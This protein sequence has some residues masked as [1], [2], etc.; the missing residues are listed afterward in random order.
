[1]ST[2]SVA[3]AFTRLLALITTNTTYLR[4]NSF[5]AQTHGR[6]KPAT[7]VTIEIFPPK[8][9]GKRADT[10][11]RRVVVAPVEA[12]AL[13][14]RVSGRLADLF[15]SHHH[16]PVREQNTGSRQG[17]SRASAEE[18]RKKQTG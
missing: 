6:H 14:H 7:H 15:A 9:P 13:A 10:G 12:E 1:M 18:I 2:A 17:Q 4:I 3:A 11:R 16:Q 8:T 5:S